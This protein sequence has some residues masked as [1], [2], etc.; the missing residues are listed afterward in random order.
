MRQ[1]SKKLGK[2]LDKWNGENKIEL[3]D[4]AIYSQLTHHKVLSSLIK[5]TWKQVVYTFQTMLRQTHLGPG[6]S[7]E[8]FFEGETDWRIILTAFY[9]HFDKSAY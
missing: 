9:T 7:S 8:T 4:Q 3:N 6:P 5:D 1:V 2:C